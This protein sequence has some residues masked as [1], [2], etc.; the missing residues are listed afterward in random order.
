MSRHLTALIVQ[1]DGSGEAF[2]VNYE[3]TNGGPDPQKATVALDP[4]V[5]DMRLRNLV[6]RSLILNPEQLR[7]YISNAA[8]REPPEAFTY[9]QGIYNE[10]SSAGPNDVFLGGQ[11]YS[12]PKNFINLRA[13]E[14]GCT[15][16]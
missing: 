2:R 12:P 13:L 16:A 5:L 3:R 1:P 15:L 4:Y 10:A 11:A 7:D 8:R 9:A 6:D 14:P